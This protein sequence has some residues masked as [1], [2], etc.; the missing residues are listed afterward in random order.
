MSKQPTVKTYAYG[1]SGQLLFTT[2][3]RKKKLTARHHC[4]SFSPCVLH[5]VCFEAIKGVEE[6]LAS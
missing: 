5:A 6:L 4:L 3:G 2:F 1:T